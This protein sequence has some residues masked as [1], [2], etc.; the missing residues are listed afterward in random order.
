MNIVPCQ[1]ARDT[2]K[3]DFSDQTISEALTEWHC[4]VVLYE[5]VLC[6]IFYGAIRIH[7][8]VQHINIKLCVKLGN[9][10]NE[11]KKE[12]RTAY[13]DNALSSAQTFRWFKCFP[14]GSKNVEDELCNRQI[15][16]TSNCAQLAHN[17]LLNDTQNDSQ[18][19]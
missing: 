19:I 14:E 15:Q 11:T 13:R 12:L 7:K 1:A 3:C 17:R 9:N 16:I 2:M 4:I 18:W 6:I 8:V 10:D 5:H